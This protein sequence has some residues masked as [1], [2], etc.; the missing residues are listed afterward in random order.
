LVTGLPPYYT[1]N[2]ELLQESIICKELT[3]P[4]HIELSNEIKD[5]LDKLLKKEEK[6]R[7]GSYI[8]IK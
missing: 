8:G 4:A 7:L 3:F 5:L 1:K 2:H 6:I